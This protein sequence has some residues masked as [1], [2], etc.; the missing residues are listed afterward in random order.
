VMQGAGLF[1]TTDGGASWTR[2]AST[3]I[4]A[5]NAISRLVI[6]PSNPLVMVASTISGIWR[7]ADG[8]TTWSQRTTT[9]ALV[10]AIDPNDPTKYVAGR[11][12]GVASW[13]TDGGLTWSNA[14]TFPNVTRVELAY[15]R[16]AS[17][18]VYACTSVQGSSLTVWRSTD[19]GKTW[20]LQTT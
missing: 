3:A 13:S 14:A 7:S 17:G 12:D 9:K 19:G 11:A 20:T 10:V 15:A 16:S 8:G 1:K 4:P 6:D 18:T 2:L 5:W